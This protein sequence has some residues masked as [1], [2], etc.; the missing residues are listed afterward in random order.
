ML[1]A[2]TGFLAANVTGVALGSTLGLIELATP[3]ITRAG[4]IRRGMRLMKTAG[5]RVFGREITDEQ[6]KQLAEQHQ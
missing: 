1:T 2:L 4:R 5:R 3:A 6:A